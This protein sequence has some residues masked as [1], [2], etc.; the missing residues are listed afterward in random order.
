MEPD[1]EDEEEEE[2]TLAD[3]AARYPLTEMALS[4]GGR[5]WTLTSVED[6]DALIDG[7]QTEADLAHFP[8]G[9]LLWESALGLAERLAAEPGLVRGKRV[10]E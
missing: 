10:L 5:R 4:I 3:L 7:A 8:Y 2:E 9:L 1:A 6:Q